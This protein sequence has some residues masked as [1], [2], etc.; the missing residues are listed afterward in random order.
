MF[1]GANNDVDKDAFAASLRK[2]FE[3][4]GVVCYAYV[5]ESQMKHVSKRA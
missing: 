2:H 5:G 1:D 3:E 4:H